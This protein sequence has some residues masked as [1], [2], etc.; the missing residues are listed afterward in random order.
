MKSSE[1]KTASDFTLQARRVKYSAR[2]RKIFNL[3]PQNGQPISSDDLVT[4]FWGAADDEQPFHRR[5]TCMGSLRSL[6]AKVLRNEEAFVINTSEPSGPKPQMIWL[7]K[8]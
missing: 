1:R 8:N 4:R 6:R 2:E 7:S 3:L 5:V